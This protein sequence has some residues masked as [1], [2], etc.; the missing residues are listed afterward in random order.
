MSRW[1]SGN[2][3]SV[4]LDKTLNPGHNDNYIEE[5]LNTKF[6]GIQI[7]NNLKLK[8]HIILVS[9]LEKLFERKSRCSGLETREYGSRDLLR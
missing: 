5:A 8:N 4:N 1:Y 3:F 6:F 9:I 7:D 2:K